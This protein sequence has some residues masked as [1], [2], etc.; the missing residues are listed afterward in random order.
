MLSAKFELELEFTIFV[1]NTA[2]KEAKRKHLVQCKT[3]INTATG[4]VLYDQCFTSEYQVV[5]EEFNLLLEGELVVS[6][7][8]S[9]K[10]THR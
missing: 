10:V 4:S 6:C 8:L 7:K 3:I 1:D 5:Y 2:Q 9:K